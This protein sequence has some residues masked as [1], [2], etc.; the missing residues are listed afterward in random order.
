MRAKIRN[1]IAVSVKGIDLTTV[2]KLEFYVSQGTL[3]FQYEPTVA[4]ATTLTVDMPLAD[5]M[6][7][8]PYLP[9]KLQFAYTVTSTGKPGASDEL[10]VPVDDLLKNEGYD[11]TD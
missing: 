3:F 6:Q 8:V 5:A 2:S 7:L 9:A 10:E 1:S 11:G 4:S